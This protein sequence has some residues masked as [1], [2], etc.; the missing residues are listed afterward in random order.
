MVNAVHRQILSEYNSW[1]VE[2]ND[3][4]D[5]FI[6]TSMRYGSAVLGG[7]MEW[8]VLVTRFGMKL[9]TAMCE[10]QRDQ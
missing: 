4:S 7:S 5:E 6:D 10:K 8:S 3:N 9:W 1:A 2:C